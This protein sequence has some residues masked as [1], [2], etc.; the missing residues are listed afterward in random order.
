MKPISMNLVWRI[1]SA[2]VLIP[3]V[4]W[5]IYQGGIIYYASI[6]LCFFVV[7]YEWIRMSILAPRNKI[8]L[9]AAGVLYFL[10]C[11]YA[12]IYL[13]FDVPQGITLVI[14]MVTAVWVSD[15]AGYAAGKT[16]KGPKIVPKISPNKTWSGF[17]AA[18]ILP[19]LYFMIYAKM[20][21]LN[22]NV[23]TYAFFLTIGF[24]GQMGDFTVSMMKRYVGVKDT[25]VLIPG[26]GGLLDRI[27]ALIFVVPIFAAVLLVLKN[28]SL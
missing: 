21:G 2:L 20:A 9:G 22:L 25:G 26:H 12:F 28:V 15:I 11:L 19:A 3:V 16:L 8:I 5:F 27:D 18:I 24:W 4:F 7:S 6:I 23:A 1:I 14:F 17:L 10:S 13:R